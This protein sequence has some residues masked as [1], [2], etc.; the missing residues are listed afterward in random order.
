MNK[1]W[2]VEDNDVIRECLASLLEIE[3][4]QVNAF[5]EGDTALKYA[6]ENPSGAWPNLVLLDL[7]TDA[8]SAQEFVDSL[9]LLAARLDLRV[10][11]ICVVS[12]AADIEEAS[13]LLNADAFFQKPFNMQELVLYAKKACSL[14]TVAG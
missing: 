12:G 2:I 7:Y 9:N 3:G 4:F 8:M 14:D 10:P 13:H 1:I 11:K 6:P 5:A